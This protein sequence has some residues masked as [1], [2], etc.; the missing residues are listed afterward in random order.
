[1]NPTDE[2]LHK[3]QTIAAK[4]QR[5]FVLVLENIHDPHNAAAICRSAD[6]FGVQEIWLI[7]ETV[8]EWDLFELGKKSSAFTSR[9]ITFRHFQTTTECLQEL[10]NEGYQIWATMLD[11]SAESL[12][13]AD[14]T[15][16]EK[17][18]LIMGN[19]HNGISEAVQNATDKKLYIPMT[20][21]AQ[22]LNVS[23]ATALCL[24]EI[25]RQRE[26]SD[27]DF[28]L[29]DKAQ[30]ALVREFY[31]KQHEKKERRR[32]KKRKGVEKAQQDN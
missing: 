6:S 24:W 13:E 26:Q 1:M 32:E 2:R 17:I 16:T 25:F 5:D 20:G 3:L 18:A 22:S 31:E 9:W 30:E 4:R 8:P 29:E 28:H 23:V 10:R 11:D 21:F 27:Q 19:E 14:F 15:E 12:L 7:C